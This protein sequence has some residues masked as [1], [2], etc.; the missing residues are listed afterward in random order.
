[1][2]RPEETTSLSSRAGLGARGHLSARCAQAQYM[3]RQ[4][5]ATNSVEAKECLG[6]PA[7]N[8]SLANSSPRPMQLAG[9]VGE[10]AAAALE[11]QQGAGQFGDGSGAGGAGQD[12]QVGGI[13]GGDTV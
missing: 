11:A 3:R 4:P 1:M 13:A 9:G 7:V 10:G 5:I 12:D 2:L 6:S 8:L